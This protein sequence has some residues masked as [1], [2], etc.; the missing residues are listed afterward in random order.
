MVT[1]GPMSQVGCAIACSGVTSA[2][3]SRVRPRNGPPLAVMTSRRTSSA[4]AAAQALGE[5]GV[6][7][8][9]RDDLARL[10]R[11]E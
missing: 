11:A 8:V 1:T 2:A 9:D 5:R 6:L 4:R 3:S 7:G 10:R